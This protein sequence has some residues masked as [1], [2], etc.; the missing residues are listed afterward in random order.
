M[1]MK[2]LIFS[3][4]LVSVVGI[5][6]AQK[7][8]DD[9]TGSWLTPEGTI[10][11]INSNNNILTGKAKDGGIVLKEIVYDDG[12]WRGKIGDPAN[13]KYYNCEVSIKEKGKLTIL[14]KVSLIRK[15]I[16]WTKVK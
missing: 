4:I 15:T 3:L 9:F 10:I 8:T 13:G 14:V 6:Q 11:V 12:K 2:K 7:F 1:K 16:V 5:T